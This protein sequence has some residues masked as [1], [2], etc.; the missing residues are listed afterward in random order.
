MYVS[1]RKIKTKT[2]KREKLTNMKYVWRYNLQDLP[3]GHKDNERKES[4]IIQKQNL[5]KCG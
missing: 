2:R 4:K 3:T 1:E 5:Q